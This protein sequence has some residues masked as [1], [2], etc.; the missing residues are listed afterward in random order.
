MSSTRHLM[1][2]LQVFHLDN[3]EA[4]WPELKARL[5]EIAEGALA[6]PEED[7]YGL[8]LSDLAESLQEAARVLPLSIP[9]AK[10]ITLAYRVLSASQARLSG[11]LKPLL[12]LLDNE[13][14]DSIGYSY[15]VGSSDR[16][17]RLSLPQS[18][19]PHSVPAES[20]A[21][22]P[23]DNAHEFTFEALSDALEA[24]RGETMAPATLKNF[25]S[26]SKTIAGLLGDLDMRAHTRA[27][28]LGVREALQETRK[29]STV[30][31]LLTHLGMV[32]SW[33]QATG[34]ITHDY[35]KKLAVTKGAESSRQA[36]TKAQTEALKA[37]SVGHLASD[38]K[39]A[40]MALG[41]ASGA[42]IGEIHQ[43]TGE[44]ITKDPETGLWLMSINDNNGK[45]LKNKF[46][47]RVV[48]LIGIPEATCEALAGTV[49]RLFPMSMSGF[50]Q[51]L[52]QA[53]R[54]V[55]GTVAGEGLSFHSL[56]H[57]L[58]TD[59]KASGC[60]V[61]TAQEILGHSSGSI[62]YDL[63]GGSASADV[64]RLAEALA[65]VR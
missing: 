50:A 29:G 34:L 15:Q 30:N 10:A 20:T 49:G 3:P 2:A 54:D 41:V 19:G 26:S 13:L 11:D 48:P 39:G 5:S 12:G 22:A 6:T 28:M 59:L 58:A 60:P 8:V 36:F 57:S 32:V 62:S 35:S 23:T 27:D 40:A 1:A 18:V 61:G 63:Y 25:R 4:T 14:A 56:R 33:S 9:Q 64:G 53:V 24:E 51:M 42:R 17:C 21:T 31:K 44:D 37:A 43:L 16:E 55:L 38:W 52:N 47:R 65:K 45:T 7:T 46:S